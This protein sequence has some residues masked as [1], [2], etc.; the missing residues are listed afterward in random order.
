MGYLGG[1]GARFFQ[2]KDYRC[3]EQKPRDCLGGAPTQ[4][5]V[6]RLGAM[7]GYRVSAAETPPK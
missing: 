7:L 6:R 1:C 2:D 4:N 3:G 5:S